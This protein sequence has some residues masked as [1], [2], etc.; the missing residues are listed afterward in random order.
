MATFIEND[1][2]TESAYH[3]VYQSFFFE[4]LFFI[5][6][7]HYLY[8]L[9]AK[10]LYRHLLRTI[11]HL[12]FIVILIGALI[13]RYYGIEGSMYLNPHEKTSHFFTQQ[14]FIQINTQQQSFSVPF[15]LNAFSQPSTIILDP[16]EHLILQ[17][18]DSFF[19]K[20]GLQ[21]SGYID[22]NLLYRHQ[23]LNQKPLRFF[24]PLS[25]QQYS[26]SQTLQSPI[27]EIK[28]NFMPQKI[29]LP[30]SLKLDSF[31]LSLY[32]GSQSPSMYESFLTLIDSQQ[33]EHKI[34]LYMNHTFSQEGYKF[35][36]T[37]YDSTG[38][39]ILSVNYDPGTLPTYIGYFLL[40][41]GM[42]LTLSH[43]QS[44]FQTL[45]RQIKKG[46][47]LLLWLLCPILLLTPLKAS[48]NTEY[49]QFLMQDLKTAKQDFKRLNTQGRSG[50]M[51]PLN[52]LNIDILHKISL[53]NHIEGLDADSVIFGIITHPRLWRNVPLIAVKNPM[54]RDEI[55][56]NN[57]NKLFT[58][59]QFFDSQG[60]KLSK[61][62]QKARMVPAAKRN[63][64][65]NELIK[66]DERL[67]I[68]AMVAKGELLRILPPSKNPHNSRWLTLKDF[69]KEDYLPLQKQISELF[70]ASFARDIIKIEQI[71]KEWRTYNQQNSPL[72]QFDIEIEIFYNQ[73]DIF[74]K[75]TFAYFFLSIC[76]LIFAFYTT[77]YQNKSSTITR[78]QTGIQI[79]A[80]LLWILHTIGL[81]LRSYISGHAPFSD[82]YESL[83]YISYSNLF[84][85]F[86]F[87]KYPFVI[88]AGSLLGGIFLFVAHLNHIDPEITNLVPVLKSFWLS[89]HVSIITA[90][91]GFFGTGALLG[92]LTLILF[93]LHS[94][95][96]PLKKTILQLSYINEV[97]LILGLFLLTTGNFLGGIWAN[98]SWG[99]YWGWD[100]K[101]S[102]A[103][104]CMMIY[105][106]ILHFR[107]LKP[108]H[109]PYYFSLLSLLAFSSI[110]MTYFGVNFYLAG[111]HSYAKG[112]PIPLPSWIYLVAFSF[113]LLWA[114]SFKKRH[115]Q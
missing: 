92:L 82:T 87:R 8:L 70:S 58:F 57:K 39:S 106:A 83:L 32:A 98:E 21:T 56:K 104:V 37:S 62:L 12:A 63:I 43:K 31:V 42:L 26:E 101:E 49:K 13:T 30:F 54:L 29:Q 60:Y 114:F 107:L 48:L 47:T 71:M 79:F 14:Y 111:K 103:F 65:E 80:F 81:I 89:I 38:G 24:Y 74:P 36:Q 41:S 88:A 86:F 59:H 1:F 34:H 100:P 112:D 61:N 2:G 95:Q 51:Q 3:L 22:V 15:F 97:A 68:F 66:V 33:K 17:V 85:L 10:K 23:T 11:F 18:I 75:L 50:R 64:Y 77:F 99:R 45:L 9:F 44:R 7:I 53:Q 96:H 35:F 94:T 93:F 102:W 105:A 113:I 6:S 20:N 72:S 16:E 67:Q 4:I 109:Y 73:I 5:L 46:Q 108:R 84:I 110:L 91:Y 27:G 19:Q 69:A 40:F 25:L 115:L 78:I 28:I 90:S 55:S 76:A 52:T